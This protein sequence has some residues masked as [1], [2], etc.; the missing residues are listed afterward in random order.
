MTE[1]SSNSEFEGDPYITCRK[2]DARVEGMHKVEYYS[3]CSCII[4]ASCISFSN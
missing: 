3:Y 1:Q 2:P 4:I